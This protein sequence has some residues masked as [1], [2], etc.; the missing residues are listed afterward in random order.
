M[1][2]ITLIATCT[3]GLEALVKREVRD[4]GFFTTA[5][6][7]GKTEFDAT[8]NDI[9][10][11]NINLRCADRVVVKLGQ[12]EAR[13]FDQLF[14]GI[15]SIPFEQW[16]LPDGMITVAGNS[17]KSQ[18]ESVRSNQSV[19]KKAVLERLKDKLKVKEF[20]ETGS[21]FTIHIGLLKDIATITLDTSG[22]GLHK[23]GYRN[24]TG[25]APIRETL[26][27]ALVVLSDWK[28][29]KPLMDPMCGSG[30]ILIEAAML[31]RNIAPGIRRT[32]ISEEWPI[33]DPQ[34][35]TK[36]RKEAEEAIL[37]TGSLQIR[38]YD[39]ELDLIKIC[40]ENAAN[41]GVDKDII[42][43][44]KDVLDLKLAD[45]M[46]TIISNAPYGVKISSLRDL[47]PI[48]HAIDATFKEQK[49][50][51]LYFLTA[52]KRFPEFITRSK[53]DKVRKLFNGNIEVNYYQYTTKSDQ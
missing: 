9:P 43:E 42:F 33:I 21:E 24:K 25:E 10:K 41:A 19:G 2:K 3:F 39:I 37:R 22:D 16:I 5:G 34:A 14:D 12:F 47:N 38:G 27:A 45:T 46:G 35:W 28:K 23:R 29:D 1:D 11:A 40:R 13:D 36:A 30:T 18:L 17:V 7:D 26:A 32:F 4:L 20:P 49:G 48:Y 6:S 52:D 15:K 50:W 53:P 8:I 31:A 51:S 44:A